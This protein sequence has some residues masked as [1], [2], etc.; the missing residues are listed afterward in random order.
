MGIVETVGPALPHNGAAQLVVG[1]QIGLFLFPFFAALFEEVFP[2]LT[3]FVASLVIIGTE[4][5][6]WNH[7]KSTPFTRNKKSWSTESTQCGTFII[8][9]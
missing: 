6:T 2:P 5:S 4:F 9:S 8:T 1:V 3:V 7:E